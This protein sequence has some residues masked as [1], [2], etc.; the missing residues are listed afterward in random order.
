[1]RSE[2][3]AIKTML[4]VDAKGRSYVR[5]FQLTTDVDRVPNVCSNSSGLLKVRCGSE[6]AKAM[7]AVGAK[8]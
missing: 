3:E 1:M 7:L 6:V 4:A 8:D 5:S 2:P